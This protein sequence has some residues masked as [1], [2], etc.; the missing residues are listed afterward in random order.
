M[1]PNK[2]EK[3][4]CLKKLSCKL[5][6]KHFLIEKLEEKQYL[7]KLNYKPNKECFL[8]NLGCM[9]EKKALPV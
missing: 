6:K 4:N 9:L 8:I 2:L 3:E 5:E 7:I 1:R